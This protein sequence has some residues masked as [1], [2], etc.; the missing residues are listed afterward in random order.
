MSTG[1][2][3]A[4]YRRVGRYGWCCAPAG[5]RMGPVVSSPTRALFAK[6]A[7]RYLGQPHTA[8]SDER[9]VFA[10]PG[11][12][13]PRH[14]GS[15]YSCPHTYWPTTSG[16]YRNILSVALWCILSRYN[17]H[18]SGCMWLQTCCD[19]V[20]E[21]NVPHPLCL[22]CARAVVRNNGSPANSTGCPRAYRYSNL[23][24]A[25]ATS[26]SDWLPGWYFPGAHRRGGD[27]LRYRG[28]GAGRTLCR[29]TE[30]ARPDPVLPAAQSLL[31]I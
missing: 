13:A 3:G 2:G 22:C 24:T 11:P 20:F 27:D 18:R 8:D 28:P 17:P 21:I 12:S 16:R 26:A 1:C 10:C 6:F 31:R 23:P 19:L 4:Q 15:P 5:T 7:V 14:C 30:P 9:G 25:V 29:R